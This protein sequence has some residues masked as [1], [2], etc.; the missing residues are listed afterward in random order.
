MKVLTPQTDAFDRAFRPVAEMLFPAHAQKIL[1]MR[2]DASLQNRIA[3]LADKANE[4]ELTEDEQAEYEGYILAND[5]VAILRRQAK[6]S[7]N[8]PVD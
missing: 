6:K 8:G 1:D 7:L 3:E 2:P 5:F 4:G